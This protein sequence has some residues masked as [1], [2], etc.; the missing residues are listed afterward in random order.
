MGISLL[1]LILFRYLVDI[2]HRLFNVLFDV[3]VCNPHEKDEK[4]DFDDCDYICNCDR[5]EY[6]RYGNYGLGLLT[7]EKEY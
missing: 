5:Y 3:Y 6:L 7:I 4:Q 1:E 2:F